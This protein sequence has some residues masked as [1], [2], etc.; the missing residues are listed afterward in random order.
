MGG[1]PRNSSTVNQLK[2]KAKMSPYEEK[3]DKRVVASRHLLFYHKLRDR[4][5]SSENR[6]LE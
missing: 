4:V 6:G 1:C 2:G 3:G 5:Y